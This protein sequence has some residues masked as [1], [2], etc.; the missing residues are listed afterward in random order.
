MF[1]DVL[2]V[3]LH[4]KQEKKNK[5]KPQKCLKSDKYIFFLIIFFMGKATL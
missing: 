4:P 2:I 5:K 3:N 1:L